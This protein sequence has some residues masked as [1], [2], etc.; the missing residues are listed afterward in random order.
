M[1]SG[2]SYGRMAAGPACRQIIDILTFSEITFPV[3]FL[4]KC[5]SDISFIFHSQVEEHGVYD[6]QPRN[7][8][9]APGDFLHVQPLDALQVV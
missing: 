9:I 3:F 6:I 4:P 8:A 2:P 5:E 1:G 7:G